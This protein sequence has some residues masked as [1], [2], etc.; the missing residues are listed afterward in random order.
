MKYTMGAAV[1]SKWVEALCPVGTLLWQLLHLMDDPIN[2]FLDNSVS[3]SLERVGEGKWV[4]TLKWVTS[5][6][7]VVHACNPSTLEV[8]AE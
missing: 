8:K 3:F 2:F 7:M 6:L 1:C 4:G 5:P